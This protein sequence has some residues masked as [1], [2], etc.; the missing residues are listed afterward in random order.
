MTFR[1][2]DKSYI[3]LLYAELMDEEKRLKN[4]GAEYVRPPSGK[5]RLVSTR[6]KSIVPMGI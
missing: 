2:I 6:V 1:H 3:Y 5:G 4:L